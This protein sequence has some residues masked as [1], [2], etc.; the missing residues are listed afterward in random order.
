MI[1]RD[2][3]IREYAAGDESAILRLFG[4]VFGKTRTAAEWSWQHNDN[5]HGRGWIAVG[6]M[7]NEILAHHAVTRAD[8]SFKGQR[9]VAGQ[10]GD[11]MVHSSVRRNGLFVELLNYCY[12]LTAADGMEATFGFP[13]RL[14][15]PGFV[16]YSKGCRIVNLGYLFRRIGFKRAW[17]QGADRIFKFLGAS[18]A[19]LRAKARR[20]RYGNDLEITLSSSL[21]DDLEDLMRDKRTYEVLALWKD[22]QYL[23]WRYENHPGGTYI[24][25]TARMR[26]TPRALMITR[27]C[28]DTIAVCDLLHRD[29]DEVPSLMLVDHVVTQYMGSPAQKIEFYGYDSGFFQFVFTSCG[30]KSIPFSPLVFAGR[31]F[32][33]SELEKAFLIPDNWTIA[34]GDTDVI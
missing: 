16:R 15:Y 17:G 4:E 5:A 26:G 7:G 32:S 11:S 25:H 20:L 29:N 8:L 33:N 24:F 2:L 23:K 9:I 34:Y 3:S 30:F 6:E 1:S 18:C 14:S 27:D 21:P 22:P 12:Q 31:V 10:S 28:G 19:G 13:N